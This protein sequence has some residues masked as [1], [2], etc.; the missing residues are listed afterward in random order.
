MIDDFINIIIFV[1]V[2]VIIIISCRLLEQTGGQL[3][4]ISRAREEKGRSKPPKLKQEK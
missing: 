3:E 1:V 4:N 2:V